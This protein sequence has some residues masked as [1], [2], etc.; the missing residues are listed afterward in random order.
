MVHRCVPIHVLMYFSMPFCIINSASS[1]FTQKI[2]NRKVHLKKKNFKNLK[3]LVDALNKPK[4]TKCG[5]LDNSIHALNYLSF[6]YVVCVCVGGG[7]Q[8]LMLN[9][10]ITI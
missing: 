9:E 10:K 4:N 5:M 8:T 6:D 7:N 3:Y 1:V 2:P